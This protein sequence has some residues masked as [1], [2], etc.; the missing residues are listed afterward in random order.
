[1]VRS[2]GLGFRWHVPA[3][4]GSYG[5]RRET[6]SAGVRLALGGA[7]EIEAFDDA[8]SPYH[9]ANLIGFSVRHGDARLQV[10]YHL[11]GEHVLRG[12]CTQDGAG[13]RLALQVGYRRTLSATGQWG[14]SGLVG[15]VEDGMLV[16]QAFED[17]DALVLWSERGVADLGVTADGSAVGA[18][19]AGDAPGLPEQGWVTVL[20]GAGDSVELHAVA[21]LRAAADSHEWMLARGRTAADARRN[22]ELARTAAGSERA[23]LVA[24]DERFWSTAPRL[25]GDWPE[26]WRRGLVYDL[27]TVRMMVRPPSGIYRHAWDAMQ[28]QAPRVVLAETAMD[29]LVLGYADPAAA[30][31][32]L[33]GTFLDAP[34]PNVPCT[35]EDGSYNMVAADG[36]VCG[37]APEWGYPAWVCAMLWSLSPDRS[38]LEQLYP[39]LAQYLRWW[40]DH[41]RHPDG[42]L[43]YACSWESGQDLSPRFGDQPTG[44]GHPIRSVR[45]VDLHAAMAQA[46]GIAAGFAGILGRLEDAT[47]W[48]ECELHLAGRAASLWNGRRWADVD[49][50]SSQPTDV[51]DVMLMTP[52]AL[53][54]ASAEQAEVVS[55]GGWLDTLDATTL[56][57]PMFAWTAVEALQATGRADQ[58]VSIVERIVDRTYRFWDAP[59]AHPDRTLPG[60]AAEYWPPHGRGGGEGY[61][62][63]AFGVH[64]LLSTIVGLR[65]QAGGVD[66]A[67]RLPAAWRMPGRRFS[68]EL[69]FRGE[70][71][72]ISIEPMAEGAVA[73]LVDGERHIREWGE[74]VTVAAAPEPTAVA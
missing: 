53:G 34:E 42:H 65:A 20:G 62:W 74:P 46:C 69:T 14:E 70:R 33:L 1:V 57:W 30:Q 44:G 12:Y 72:S 71:R 31:Q 35:R 6:W 36:T 3:F 52:L 19:L 48:R 73:V 2:W 26:H 29:A 51:D 54:V 61:G 8:H 24:A 16:L 22:L 38:W 7:A 28:I 32:L 13:R 37:T 64:L 17:G 27:E 4:A 47:R 55:A 21:G 18:W 43:F 59:Q 68:L 25:T 60:I 40:L 23:R 39:A 49:G 56:V 11:V 50:Q 15:R 66:L 45:P 41:R 5:G 58:A 63:G 10:E 9:S 67:P